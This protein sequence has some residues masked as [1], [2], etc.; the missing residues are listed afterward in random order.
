M[1]QGVKIWLI[2]ILTGTALFFLRGPMVFSW[3]LYPLPG[4]GGFAVIFLKNSL[5]SLTT[6]YLG[7]ILCFAEMKIYRKV[8]PGTYDFLEALTSPLYRLLGMLNGT[9]RELKPFF[10]S[11]FFYLIFVPYLSL[12][13]NGLAPGFLLAWHPR[14]LY[15]H[16]VLEIPAMLGSAFLGLAIFNGLKESIMRGD[17]QELEVGM[18]AAVGRRFL[19]RTLLIQ[20]VLLGTA[21]LEAN[22]PA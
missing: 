8:S 12:F 5:A 10:R 19:L 20:G 13:V 7:L 1:I 14:W 21:F 2:G 6:I 4:G 15:P 3:M 16:G 18:R 9:F 11:C 22:Y 17:I